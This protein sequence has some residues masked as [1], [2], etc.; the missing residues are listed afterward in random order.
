MRG[1]ATRPRRGCRLP[2]RTR[3]RSRPLPGARRRALDR[4]GAEPDHR[5]ADRGRQELAGLRARPQG[6]P[7]QSLGALPAHSQAVQPI[8][9]SARGDG[10]YPRLMR[11]LGGVKLLILDDWGL[12]PLGP[13][14][15][16]DLLEIVED[17][18][19]R[20]ATLITSQIPDRP[21]AWPD[22]RSHH[23]RRHPRPRSSTMPIASSSSGESLRK[24]AHARTRHR[25]TKP[26]QNGEI[27]PA[28]RA[29]R[30]PGRHQSERPADLD[31]NA[32]R[33]HVGMPGRLHRNPQSRWASIVP[34]QPRIS[35]SSGRLS[36]LNP[37]V[38]QER[39][40]H[41]PQRTLI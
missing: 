1:C 17:R 4:G 14:Q 28:Q 31:R 20:G 39:L 23:G 19:G 37:K 32:G 33:H 3:A 26:R 12:E 21:L 10:R 29:I 35:H 8:S 5:R 2:H 6:L 41:D 18:Y 7:R 22:R 16:H 25:L 36:P 40:H 13:E 38:T 30:H 9:R 11:A 15:R 24:T 27:T 34:R